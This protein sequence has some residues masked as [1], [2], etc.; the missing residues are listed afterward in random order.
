MK[1]RHDYI[2]YLPSKLYDEFLSIC[3]MDLLERPCD[4]LESAVYGGIPW[5]LIPENRNEIMTYWVDVV[6]EHEG[7]INIIMNGHGIPNTGLQELIDAHNK[8]KKGFVRG[9]VT[10][11]EQPWTAKEELIALEQKAVERDDFEQAIIYR[12]K[13][14][15]L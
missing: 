12:D 11:N 15:A 14:K 9:S 10:T 4:S 5:H 1:T 6:T 3:D 2:K 8:Y 13:I 7:E